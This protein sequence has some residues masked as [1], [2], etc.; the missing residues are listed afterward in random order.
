M[1]KHFLL[2]RYFLGTVFF[3][4]LSTPTLASD[5]ASP[6]VLKAGHTS[7]QPWLL[8]ESPPYP[9][10][11]KPNAAR[12][13]LGKMLFFDP[14]ASRDGNMSCASCHSPLLGW[15]DGLSTGRGFKSQKLARATPTVIN[16]AYNDIQ[17]WDGREKN[18]ESQAMGPMKAEVEMNTDIPALIEFLS[19]NKAYSSAFAQAYPNE[20]ISEA[21]ISKAIASFERTVI[22]RNSRFDKWVKGDKKALTKQEVNGFRLFLDPDK[23]NCEVC[24]SAPNFTDNG[25]HNIGLASFGKDN[26]DRG[27][28]ALRPLRIMT[29]AFKTPTIRDI[30]YTAPY[31]HDGSAPDLDA[32]MEHYM[33]GGEVKTHLSPNLKPLS[34]TKREREDIV[35]FMRALSSPSEPFVLPQL[36]L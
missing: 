13:S 33:N 28:H 24:H 8:P 3:L 2:L 17:M 1:K 10:G 30:S 14:R 20:G 31:F 5:N 26:S 29:G 22:S 16:T 21:T 15:S 36:P 12:I 23:G 9:E 11:N 19:A 35:A 7:L 25:F 4:F 18:L 34:L 6:Y 32:V 27:R